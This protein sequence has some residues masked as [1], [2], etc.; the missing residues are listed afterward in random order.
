MSD[1]PFQ[2]SAMYGVGSQMPESEV[3]EGQTIYGH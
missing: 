2:P 3:G 1:L